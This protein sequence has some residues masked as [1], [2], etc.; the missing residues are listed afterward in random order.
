M[1]FQELTKKSLANAHPDI[2]SVDGDNDHPLTKL[3]SHRKEKF[4]RAPDG[5]EVPSY[6]DKENEAGIS[7]SY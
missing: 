1:S 3:E 5:Q 7:K 6:H 4:K 2:I